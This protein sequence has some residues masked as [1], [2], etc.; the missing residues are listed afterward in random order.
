MMPIDLH[1]RLIVTSFDVLHSFSLP[2]AGIKVDAVPGRLNRTE[3]FLYRMGVF[4]GQC[5]EICGRGHGF[6]PIN[7]FSISFLNF[8]IGPMVS[9]LFLD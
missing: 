5:S 6:M 7:L 3:I 1:S 8:L 4:H 9:N 2:S